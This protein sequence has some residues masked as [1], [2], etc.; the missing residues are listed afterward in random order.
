M[1]AVNPFNN[2]MNLI[3]ETIVSAWQLFQNKNDDMAIGV[4]ME[5]QQSFPD[6]QDLQETLTRLF[7]AIH[8]RKDEAMLALTLEESKQA[9]TTVHVAPPPAA[10]EGEKKEQPVLEKSAIVPRLVIKLKRPKKADTPEAAP[11]VGASATSEDDKGNRTKKRKKVAEAVA[12]LWCRECETK[13]TPQWRRGPEGLATLCN[14]CGLRYASKKPSPATKEKEASDSSSRA[15]REIARP[16]APKLDFLVDVAL[17]ASL[18]EAPARPDPLAAL[19]AQPVPVRKS[20]KSASTA[21]QNYYNEEKKQ[22]A[23]KLEEVS[24]SDEDPAHE[25]TSVSGDED[26]LG[27]NA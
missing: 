15:S 12:D 19:R 25:Y 4:V 18:E 6:S 13:V 16:D 27:S 8:K 17:A 20:A 1:Q 2:G 11:T 3:S 22:P 14:A 9:T 10:A 7:Q 24:S 5:C 21:L 23:N 26:S